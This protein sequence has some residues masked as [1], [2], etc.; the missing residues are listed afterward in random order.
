VIVVRET[1]LDGPYR[2]LAP[3]GDSENDA[4]FF[5][6]RER[7]TAVTTANLVGARLTVLYGPSGVGKSSLLRAGVARSVR[8]LGR[9]RAVGR[10][11]D[12]ACVVFASW[13]AAD[14][15]RSL[16][17][18]IAAEVAP[19]VSPTT[20]DPPPGATLADVA[21]HWTAALDGEICLILDQFEEY[22]VY[23]GDE[24]SDT[25]ARELPELVTRPTLR[26]NV[27]LS[28][29]DDALARLDAFKGSLPQVFTNPRRL[30]RLARDGAQIG[31]AHV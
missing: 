23:H 1:A 13:S 28:L 29:R 14:P 21:E 12:L 27:L 24:P 20:P 2:G 3:F 18:A 10:G 30:D 9:S 4:R 26:A 11:A 17:D 25:F 15:A 5:F 31:R 22:F 16:A 6:G 7:E 19:L 8:E